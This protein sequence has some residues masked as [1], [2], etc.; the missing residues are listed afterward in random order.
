[1]LS[2]GW[3]SCHHGN[4]RCVW[5]AMMVHTFIQPSYQ[6]LQTVL[7]GQALI[8]PTRRGRPFW[9][10]PLP[11]LCTSTV[12]VCVWP[13]VCVA[14]YCL[15]IFAASNSLRSRNN[16]HSLVFILRL[17]MR[18]GFIICLFG[19]RDEYLSTQRSHIQTQVCPR[20][21]SSVAHRLLCSRGLFSAISHPIKR[22]AACWFDLNSFNA[23]P[24][25]HKS[26]HDVSPELLKMTKTS[27]PDNDVFPKEH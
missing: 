6:K 19:P 12:L 18:F 5:T 23:F 10:L 24:P 2:F 20:L 26:H 16:K 13:C 7:K 9:N 17:K 1:M 11:C 8:E 22:E 3:L 25:L 27:N 14:V 15:S 21:L 4:V